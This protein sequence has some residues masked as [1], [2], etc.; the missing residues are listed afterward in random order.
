[1]ATIANIFVDQGSDYS[2]VVSV[3]DSSGQ[4]INLTGFTVESEIRKYYGSS[5]GYCFNAT[6]ADAATGKVRIRL[7]S[8]ESK[9][10]PPGRWLYDVYVVSSAGIRR[11]VIEGVMMLIPQSTTGPCPE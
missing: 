5:Q 7:P 2:A 3:V 11:R 9:I 4:P 10:M 1:M 6:V 8:A